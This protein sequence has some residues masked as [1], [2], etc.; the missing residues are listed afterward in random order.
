MKKRGNLDRE[1]SECKGEDAVRICDG[2]SPPD[3]AGVR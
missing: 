1:R 3:R 2:N